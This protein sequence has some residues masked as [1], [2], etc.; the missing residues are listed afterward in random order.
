M[1]NEFPW[2]NSEINLFDMTLGTPLWLKSI[3][4]SEVKWLKDDPRKGV[5]AVVTL[6][7][8]LSKE[9]FLLRLTE[10]RG[11]TFDLTR[12]PYSPRDTYSPDMVVASMTNCEILSKWIEDLVIIAPDLQG[13]VGVLIQMRV[14]FTLTLKGLKP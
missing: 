6:W 8:P 3:N 2:I 5:K 13:V 4:V 11:L 12:Q 1:K 14:N 7:E 10:D 9:S